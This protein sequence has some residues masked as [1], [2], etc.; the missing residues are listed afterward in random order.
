[1]TDEQRWQRDLEEM[2]IVLL[3]LCFDAWVAFWWL[4]HHSYIIL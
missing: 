1:M 2:K 4:V 3:S